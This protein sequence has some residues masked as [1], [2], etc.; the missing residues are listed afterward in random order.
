MHQGTLMSRRLPAWVVAAIAVGMAVGC[1]RNEDEPARGTRG[2]PP[3]AQ[4]ASRASAALTRSGAAAS[5]APAPSPVSPP[6]ADLPA[7][8]PLGVTLTTTGP[9]Y[10]PM[11]LS[12]G[13]PFPRGQLASLSHLRL[14]APDGT[15]LP[16][17]FTPLA[18][19]PDGSYKVVLVTAPVD[20]SPVTQSLML[21]SD[22][23]TPV[24][25]PQTPLRVSDE[26]D[27]IVITT[28]PAQVRI[29]KTRFS[30]FD[31]AWVDTDGN[32]RF[33]DAE[34]VLSGPGDIFLL[35]GKGGTE[36]RAT[37]ESKPQVT[38]EE[39]GPMRAVVRAAGWLR[40][41]RGRPMSAFIVRLTA[42]AGQDAIRVDYT[43]V[44]PREESDV[45]AHRT[46]PAFQAAGYGIRLPLALGEPA[47]GLFGGDRFQGYQAF[48]GPLGESQY[49]YQQGDFNY[50]DGALK[51]FT[52]Y[53]EGVGKGERADGWVDA[54]DSRRGVAA[55]VRY[56]WEQFPK[57]LAIEQRQLIVYLHPT[58]ATMEP[59][60]E[61]PGGWSKR[62]RRPK[63]LYFHREGGAKTYQLLFRFHAGQ[64]DPAVLQGL[65]DTFKDSPRLM[66]SPAWLCRSGVFGD[67]IEAGDWSAGHDASLLRDV[68][69][70]SIEQHRREGSLALPF[71][72][73]DFGDRVRPGWTGDRN[74]VRIPGFYN[75]THVGATTFLLQYLRTGDPRWYELGEI[76]TR[77]WMDL[78]VSHSNRLGYWK[79]DGKPV[80]FG[81][82]EGLMIK[83]DMIDHDA[84][85]MHWGHAHISGLVEYYF[86]TGDQR[87][88]EVLREVGDWWA[89]AAPVFFKT[90]IA[91]PHVAE[92][93]RDFGWPL[94]VLNKAYQATGDRRYHEA[95]AQ[96][97]RHLIEWWQQPSD[98]YINGQN[99]GHN[100]WRKGTGWWH[101][102]PRQDNSP[103][104]P[105]GQILYNGTNP[106]MA[107]PL[108][109]A[110]ITFHEADRE[111]Q[112]VDDALTEQML[113]QTM[114][115]VVKWGWHPEK[116][117]FMYSEAARD[118][119]GGWNHLLY[120]LA[121]CARRVQ[122]GVEH[123]EWYDT[124]PQ[125]LEIAQRA[126][127]DAQVIKPRSSTDL[128]FYGYEMIFPPDFFTIMHELEQSP[129]GPPAP[130]ADPRP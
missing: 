75:D 54:S 128:G 89:N 64:G 69:D 21:R 81:P 74:G 72:W 111:L 46:G 53:Y 40:D 65:Y 36:F 122:A 20:A 84:R 49:L 35:D 94:F 14:E 106:W 17:Q 15:V 80:G 116:R 105:K 6:P 39:S 37:A 76:A 73:R 90:P 104:P 118:T 31:Q 99:V 9:L 103:A 10:Q 121:Y 12:S 61:P 60:Q 18:Q 109:S 50:V 51:P 88:Y 127:R 4:A 16:A 33:D 98:H 34:A 97:M 96:V 27:A 92:A 41:D 86:L 8:P 19:W 102:W 42:Y 3:P 52:F 91:K 66:P 129:A 130:P 44:D 123:P 93:E 30:L 126:Y 38:L 7:G 59:D 70:R 114:N 83:H 119:D 1:G 101:M 85:N 47:Q 2:G 25:A 78:D 82:G 87:A 67:L 125:W 5:L 58:R 23:S 117:Y 43:L 120:P 13:V 29:S 45:E 26:Q 24:P 95:A 124:A 112:L 108:L 63:S 115:Y 79:R 48:G 57:E 113:L 22:P 107:G 32:G 110:V 100:D 77:H 62:Y 71:G 11:A 55:M 68:Y 28:G 56:F